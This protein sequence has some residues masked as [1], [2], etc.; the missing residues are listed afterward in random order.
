MI[1]KFSR[2]YNNG[3]TYT[4][5]HDTEYPGGLTVRCNGEYIA[6]LLFSDLLVG[7]GIDFEMIDSEGMHENGHH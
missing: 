2:K 7:T 4:I 6:F 1:E 3:K 5:E